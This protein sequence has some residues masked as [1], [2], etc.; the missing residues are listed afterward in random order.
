MIRIEH[1]TFDFTASGEDFARRL[2][3]DWDGFFHKCVETVTEECLSNHDKDNVMLE[4]DSLDLDLGIIPEADFYQE[5]PKRLKAELLK[6]ISEWERQS[7]NN[8]GRSCLTRQENLLYYLEYGSP[9]P[10]W[11]D[12]DF[13]PEYELA[14]TDTLP[15]QTKEEI[16]ERIA[17]LCLRQEQAMSRL[18]W[19]T[20]NDRLL[21]SVYATILHKYPA[22]IQEK[23][24]LLSILLE[25]KPGIP[26]EF[27][28]ETNDDSSLRNMAEL[29]ETRSVKSFIRKETETHAEVDLPPYWHYLYEWL[30]RYY[31][32]NGI[33]IFGSKADYVRHLHYRLLTFVNKRNP[34][35]YLSKTELT[36]EFLLEVFG[37]AYYKK[38]LNAI[39]MMQPRNTDGTPV[40]NGFFSMELYRTFLQLSLLLHPI[41][42]KITGKSTET[43]TVQWER[44][45]EDAVAGCLPDEEEQTMEDMVKALSD[46]S[47]THYALRLSLTRMMERHAD[48]L[49]VWMEKEADMNETTRLAEASDGVTLTH[50]TDLLSH[51]AGFA[52]PDAFRQLTAWLMYR[53]PVSLMANALLCFVREP[54]WRTF[55]PYEMEEYF[56]S[57]LYGTTETLP[58]MEALADESL[59][60]DTR[61]RL[62][63]RY[64]HVCPKRLLEFVRDSAT[65]NVIPLEKWM[66]WTET[67]DWLDLIA[68]I[69]LSKAE[70]LQQITNSLALPENEKRLALATYIVNGDTKEWPYYTNEETIRNIVDVLPERKNVEAGKKEETA[71]K[72]QTEL[73][74]YLS[75][76]ET[77][78]QEKTPDVLTVN[79]AGLC[80]LAP[81]FVRLFDILGYLD[82]ER[83]NFRSTASKIRAVFLLQYIACGNEREWRET[84][85]AFNRILTALPG[86]VALP[87]GLQLTD[88]ERQ[89]ADGMVTGVKA[90]WAQ[91]NG[92][93]AEGF[94]S[95]F[96][97]RKGILIEEE[98]RWMMTVEGKAYD[99]LLDTIPWSFRQLRLPWLKKYVQVKWHEKQIF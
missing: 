78:V 60:K 93:S 3:A 30:V 90:N 94:R 25:T 41:N 44:I 87:K 76:K 68:E 98:K 69:S 16:V 74:L 33:A 2:Y 79:N 65:R 10:E 48:R 11:E 32:Y 45:A 9:K 22:S 80:L 58:D 70:L 36:T 6:N 88:E 57:R 49:L 35:A 26:V 21:K 50:W 89:T 91:M 51:T 7:A 64:L 40:D 29:L 82:K 34:A 8:K 96:I 31:P 17:A 24:R 47:T 84:E 18:L 62:F 13:E 73:Y 4:I 12:T 56:F 28:R 99:I 95:S 55:T 14:W 20:T 92:T 85:L 19:Q 86:N 37:A 15:I 77:T 42:S 23:K 5:F 54:G 71:R 72:I 75:E 59:P 39:Y 63:R 46:Q 83:R 53:I 97:N 43:D 81:W 66:E 38:V 67:T 52:Y 27:V 1:M 61:K